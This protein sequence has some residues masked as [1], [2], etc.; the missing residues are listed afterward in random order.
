MA[1]LPC[2]GCKKSEIDAWTER[3]RHPPGGSGSL[4]LLK[5]GMGHPGKPGHHPAATEALKA[6]L[7]VDTR[8]ASQIARAARDVIGRVDAGQAPFLPLPSIPSVS[9][10][11]IFFSGVPV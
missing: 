1:N 6:L 5:I 10:E 8:E 2:D 9:H 3:G 7:C 11:T 4:V